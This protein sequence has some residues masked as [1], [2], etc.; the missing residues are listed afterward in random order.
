MTI[1]PALFDVSSILGYY[2]AQVDKLRY[3]SI[4]ESG[5]KIA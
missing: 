2:Q 5:R 1:N 4:K 3:A